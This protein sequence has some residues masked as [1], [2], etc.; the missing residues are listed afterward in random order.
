MARLRA[1]I[2]GEPI[3]VELTVDELHQLLE[4]QRLG[5]TM[6]ARQRGGR[7]RGAQEQVSVHDVAAR[8]S[9]QFAEGI[10][11]TWPERIILVEKP[12]LTTGNVRRFLIQRVLDGN[13][14]I[15]TDEVSSRFFG[16]SLSPTNPGDVTDLRR[17]WYC[18]REAKRDIEEAVSGRWEDDTDAPLRQG[19][20]RSW[21]LVPHSPPVPAEEVMSYREGR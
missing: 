1:K 10:R 15:S 18:V 16:R 20:S 7:R 17:L 2:K 11:R 4:K 12:D 3:T 14:R 5:L 8:V 13:L 21:K 6:E 19:S 9:E